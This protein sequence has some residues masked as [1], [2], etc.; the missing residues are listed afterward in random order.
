MPVIPA[1]WRLR[2]KYF[3]FQLEVSLGYVRKPYHN[4]FLE[5]FVNMEIQVKHP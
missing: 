5:G 1:L 4:F 2:Q 3:E